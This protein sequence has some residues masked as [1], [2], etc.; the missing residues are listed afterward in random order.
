MYAIKVEFPEK[1]HCKLL[2]ENYVNDI[3]E[4]EK[5]CFTMPWSKKQ[6]IYAFTQKNF[7]ALGVLYEECL[8]AYVSFY[9][10]ACELEILNIAVDTQC[11]Q[12][13]Y[14]TYLL[15]NL[16]EVA[17]RMNIEKVILEVRELNVPA[18]ALYQ[19]L[20]FVKVGSR[21]KYYADTNEDA[22][23]YQFLIN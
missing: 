10:M 11:R 15:A 1:I 4:L 9:H 7:S 23:I 19:N 6:L 17:K 5:K 20:G 13:G 12:K 8:T 2:L 14:G 16:L 18:I 3:Y 22:L 21:L